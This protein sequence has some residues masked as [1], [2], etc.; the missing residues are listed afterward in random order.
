MLADVLAQIPRGKHAIH[1][2]VFSKKLS[3]LKME[4]GTAALPEGTFRAYLLAD[5]L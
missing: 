1:L 3:A 5:I 2:A 4:A